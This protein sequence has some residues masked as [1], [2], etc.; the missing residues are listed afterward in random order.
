MQGIV[1]NYSLSTLNS[2]DSAYTR[3]KEQWIGKEMNNFLQNI[4]NKNEI[5]ENRYK[6]GEKIFL[7]FY[8]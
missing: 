5:D 4:L 7:K 2:F 3:I 1:V 8:N 6:N